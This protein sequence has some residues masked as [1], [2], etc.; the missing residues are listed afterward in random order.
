MRHPRILSCNEAVLVIIDVQESFRKHLA[1]VVNLTRNISIM[2]EAA[3]ILQ[4]PVFLTEQYPQGLGHTLAEITACIGE[5]KY[6]EKKAFSCTGAAGF[7]DELEATGRRQVVICGIEAHVC[8]NQTVHDLLRRDYTVHLI[9]DAISS[10]AARHKDLAIAKMTASGAVLSSVET[11]LFE[12]LV[13]S[14]SDKFKAVQR[15]IR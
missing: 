11:A 15:L 9:S 3:K 13:E 10:R 4:V 7:L 12:M 14:G 6:F 1:D 8:V 5:H 2:S